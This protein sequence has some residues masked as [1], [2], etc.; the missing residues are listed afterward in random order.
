[1]LKKITINIIAILVALEL[2]LYFIEE[3]LSVNI[4]HYNA[5][6]DIVSSLENRNSTLI[7]GNSL[8]RR[9][10]NKEQIQS[11][12]DELSIGIIYPDDTT[13]TEWYWIFKSKILANSNI[14]TLA[15]S[16]VGEQLSDSPIQSQNIAR[17]GSLISSRELIDV[18][19]FEDFD[20]GESMKLILTHFSKLFSLQ[21]QI[22]RRI[23]DLLPSYR[24]AARTIN[25][26][27][28][29]NTKRTSNK[30]T[31]KHLSELVKLC[32]KHKL[33][34]VVIAMPQPKR[35]SIEEGVLTMKENGDLEILDAQNTENIT[36]NDY[37]DGY[38]LNHKGARKLS[39]FIVQNKNF[40]TAN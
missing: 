16:F 40:F 24:H 6:E 18:T 17:I 3:K 31:Y 11:Q 8:V 28:S 39:N 22:N 32:K 21:E 30:K 1:M 20:L 2:L 37:L 19:Q 34:L 26:S 35:Y 27:L 9:G 23:L 5:I 36:N 38:H 4:R 13:I 10:I 25:N 12:T 14:N 15:I 7:L 33:K 29:N